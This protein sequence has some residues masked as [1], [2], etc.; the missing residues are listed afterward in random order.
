MNRDAAYGLLI[1]G[2]LMVAAAP[3]AL[4][5]WTSSVRNPP[6]HQRDTARAAVSVIGSIGGIIAVIGFVVLLL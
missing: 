2:V 1:V 5:P 6:S 4:R 3:I